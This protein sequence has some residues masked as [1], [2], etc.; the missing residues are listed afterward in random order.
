VK[1]WVQLWI[2]KAKNDL[3]T[4]LDELST[5]QPATDTI[6]FHMQQCVEKYLKAILVQ[7]GQDF[8]KTHDIAEL[9]ELCKKKDSS[10]DILYDLNAD[11]L[12][13]YGIEVRYP[14]DFYMPSLEET[15]KAVEITKKT[16]EFIN[17]RISST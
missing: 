2:Q 4:G 15:H 10:F 12:T 8:R 17:T 14:D 7:N 1:D 13:P 16:L 5:E 6:C 9:I 11:A 3:K